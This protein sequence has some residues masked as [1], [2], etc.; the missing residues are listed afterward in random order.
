M[1]VDTGATAVALS[2]QQA[3]ALGI[4]FAEAQ[5]GW[6]STA[7]GRAKSWRVQLES[8]AIGGV[9]VYQVP[10]VVI[11]GSYPDMVLLGNSFLQKVDLDREQGVL[12]IRSRW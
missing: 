12:V 8:V 4:R 11:E 6:V 3:K 5:V 2:E 1:M 10:A 7:S 9:I